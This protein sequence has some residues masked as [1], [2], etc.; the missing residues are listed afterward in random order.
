MT[1]I[2]ILTGES[3]DRPHHHGD[4]LSATCEIHVTKETSYL[5][6]STSIAPDGTRATVLLPQDQPTRMLHLSALAHLT[7]AAESGEGAAV[8][9]A[10][11]ETSTPTIETDTMIHVTAHPST[12]RI[13]HE[14]AR[15][16][17]A[18]R[19]TC[20]KI[21]ILTEGSAMIGGLFQE[22]MILILAQPGLPSLDRA[23]STRTADRA[24]LTQ[25]MFQERLQGQHR[26]PRITHLHRTG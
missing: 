22:S 8:L 11:D 17:D 1:E 24:H 13:A 9:Q 15:R 4:R 21:E 10:V 7:A 3:D 23:R 6:T 19:E 25:D 18:V 16:L 14:A 2:V 12:V 26:I 20:E 5:E